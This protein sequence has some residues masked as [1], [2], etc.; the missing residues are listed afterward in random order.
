EHQIRRAL[1]LHE[2][3]PYYQPQFC[4][5]TGIVSG[6]E[7]LARWEHPTHGLLP[8]STFIPLLEQSEWLSE[9]LF[10]Q[11]HE[12]L[13]LRQRAKKRGYSLNLSFNLNTA[14][15]TNAEWISRIKDI[16]DYHGIQGSNLTF[17]LTETG[18]LDS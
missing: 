16:I 10:A 18:L 15:L 4:L 1:K 13:N 6:V 9:F 7:V 17:E 8:P 12:A 14:Q 11:M 2:F 5:A 3:I